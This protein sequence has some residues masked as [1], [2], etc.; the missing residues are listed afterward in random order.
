[1]AVIG[2]VLALG[3]GLTLGL[4]GAGGSI[5]S[6]PILV[7]FLDVSPVTA[8]GYSLVLVGATALVGGIRYLRQGQVDLKTAVIFALPSF[9]GVYVSRAWLLPII[10]DPM[11]KTSWLLVSKDLG[12]MLLFVVLM[13]VAAGFMI[14]GGQPSSTDKKTPQ[15]QR[16]LMITVEGAAV[17]IITGILGAGGGFLII[18]ALVFLAGLEMKV[19]VGTSLLIIAAKSLL[20]FMGDLQRGF[21]LDMHLVSLFLACTFSGMILGV[22][23]SRFIGGARLKQAFGWFTLLVACAII[24]QEL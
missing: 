11:L 6:I 10:P 23:L 24:F 7:Y 3:M 17:G 22:Y 8:T 5:L 12:I 16:W 21:D 15:N 18:P 4:I 14:R 13:V 2:Y 20:G 1:M 9:I 19:A